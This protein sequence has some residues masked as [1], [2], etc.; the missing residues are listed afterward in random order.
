[1]RGIIVG[2]LDCKLQRIWAYISKFYILTPY[3]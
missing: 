2:I 3:Q 1:M